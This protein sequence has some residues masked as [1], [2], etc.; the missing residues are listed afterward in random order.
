MHTQERC[1]TEGIHSEL[2]HIFS[3]WRFW[4]GSNSVFI[5]TNMYLC[6]GHAERRGDIKILW[7]LIRIGYL[8]RSG[9]D[10]IVCL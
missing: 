5:R 7:K 2:I 9:F 8:V 3:I 1:W 10:F 4:F 6:A